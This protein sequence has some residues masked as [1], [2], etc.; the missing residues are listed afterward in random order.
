[1]MEFFFI[2][3]Y[4]HTCRHSALGVLKTKAI[5]PGVNVLCLSDGLEWNIQADFGLIFA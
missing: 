2:V 3:Y 4:S 1:M 5:D